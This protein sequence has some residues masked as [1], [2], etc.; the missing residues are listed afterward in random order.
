MSLHPQHS[1]FMKYKDF[2]ED[3]VKMLEGDHTGQPIKYLYSSFDNVMQDSCYYVAGDEEQIIQKFSTDL[4]EILGPNR[5]V[6]ELGCGSAFAVQHKTLHLLEAFNVASYAA[7]DFWMSNAQAA[8][9]IVQSK[10]HHLPA[11]SL[12]EDFMKAD[13]NWYNLER[14]VIFMLGS[15]IS[16]LIAERE[17]EQPEEVLTGVFKKIKQIGGKNS[18]FII[19]Y[20]TS[21]DQHVLEKTYNT[22]EHQNFRLSII[23]M[24]NEY[25][26]SDRLNKCDFISP[27]IWYSSKKL[28]SHQ[29]ITGRNTKIDFSEKTTFLSAGTSYILGNS[30]KYPKEMFSEIAHNQGLQTKGIFSL[31]SSPI[32]LQCLQ[33][34]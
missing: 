33:V 30:Y 27:S 32:I 15:T 12:T 8:K 34:E 29:L 11:V 17:H 4:A 28:L 9:A 5:N 18:D 19:T 14:P 16:N 21:Q 13:A 6:L 23:P 20:D 22:P 1:I 2:E 31:E 10:M 26:A 7:N 24:I 25:L 3:V